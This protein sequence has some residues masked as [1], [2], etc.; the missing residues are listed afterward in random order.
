M[1][2]ERCRVTVIGGRR[3]VDLAVP[4]RAPIAE[5]APQLAGL[6]GQEDHDTLPAAW[7]LG[8]AGRRPFPPSASLAESGVVDGQVL[9]LG[10]V[11]GGETDEPIV[12]DLDELVAD[13]A[14][15]T[16][17]PRWDTRAHAVTTL[18][19][20]LGW[21]VATTAVLAFRTANPPTGSLAAV[22]G[23]MLPLVALTVRRRGWPVAAPMVLLTALGAVPCLA[24]AGWL[25]P[26]SASGG[27]RTIAAALGA[28]VGAL[29]AI[30]AVPGLATLIVETG[31]LVAAGIAALL[32]G[33]HANPVQSAA[34]VAV[35]AFGLLALAPWLAAQSTALA[36][37][38]TAD[39][40]EAI[41]AAVRTGRALLVAWSAAMS[42]IL[43]V[44]LV[45]LSGSGNSFGTW[46]AACLAVALLVRSRRSRL[47]IEAVPVVAAGAAGLFTIFVAAP[48]RLGAPAQAILLLPFAIGIALLAT[49]LLLAFRRRH[50]RVPGAA[51]LGLLGTGCTVAAVPLALGVLG[52]FH[53]LMTIGTHL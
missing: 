48:T 35:A 1:A 28:G 25:L 16:G 49:G 5:Y 10:D 12:L 37:R 27:G 14:D 19:A 32:V 46:L 53:H 52:V 30:C 38:A 3:R 2:D 20:G 15:N 22:V 33:V 34:I 9:Y 40:A 23:L 51:W 43:A 13:A 36:P 39:Q 44:A 29:A 45:V 7:S 11:T 24:A 18:A 41:P 21:L 8:L 26:G 47:V 4:A 42:A 17:G 50:E 31:A 6:C